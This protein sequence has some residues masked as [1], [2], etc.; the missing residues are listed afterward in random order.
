MILELI[1]E[2]Q[3]TRSFL[4][5]E[6]KESDVNKIVEAG[7]LAPSWINIQPWK[8]IV[9][10]DEITKGLLVKLSSGQA[11][12]QKAPV[13][14]GCVLDLDSWEPDKFKKILME[15]PGLTEEK[16]N[17]LLTN[18]ALY[19]YLQG[20]ESTLLRTLEQMSYAVSYMTLE[21]QSLGLASCIVGGI[22][23][24]LTDMNRDIYAVIKEELGLSDNMILS[25]LLLV[26]YPEEKPSAT[27]KL[28]KN[29]EDVVF[30][31]K[32]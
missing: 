2:R 9:I 21:A 29:I 11:H 13:I 30:F 28:R 7:V 15:K 12:I 6:V 14:I 4:P 10:R 23:N 25:T 5:K 16:M 26:G 18:K 19:P 24:E 20:K 17:Y 3:S 32:I 27:P 31:E 1:K 8:F 22:G